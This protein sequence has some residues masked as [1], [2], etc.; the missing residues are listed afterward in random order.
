MR[1]LNFVPQIALVCTGRENVSI[2]KR[3]MAT[4]LVTIV[5]LIEKPKRISQFQLPEILR[6]P[7]VRRLEGFLFYVLSSPLCFPK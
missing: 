2:V 4:T 3:I 1:D 5:M 7:G 6:E